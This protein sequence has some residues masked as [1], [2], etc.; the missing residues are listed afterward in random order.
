VN[1]K[2]WKI[3]LLNL[4][5]L[6]LAGAA[7]ATGIDS[8]RLER[9]QSSLYSGERMIVIQAPQMDSAAAVVRMDDKHYQ[10]SLDG[11][12]FSHKLPIRNELHLRIGSFDPTQK[13][14]RNTELL[15][16]IDTDVDSDQK[17]YIVQ[18]ETQ[19]LAPIQEKI[20]HLGGAIYRPLPD[21]ALLVKMDTTTHNAVANLPFV[22]WTGEY[23]VDYKLEPELQSQLLQGPGRTDSTTTRYRVLLL[24]GNYRSEAETEVR[25]LGGEV[26]GGSSQRLLEIRL[27]TRELLS[28][29]Q[30]PYIE[31]VEAWTPVETDMDLVREYGGANFLETIPLPGYS[32]QGVRGEVLDDGLFLHHSDFLA[33]PPLLHGSNQSH[34]SHGTPV[35]GI[36]FGDGSNNA[37]ARGLLPNAEQGIFAS[38][39][40]LDNRECH[41]ARLVDPAGP[42]RA[43]FQTNSWGH[44]RTTEYTS[45]SAQL[46]DIIFKHDLLITQSQSNS[47]NQYSRPE[48]WAKNVVSVGGFRHYNTLTKGS[49]GWH[50]S[51]STGPAADG[52]IK[53]DLSHFYDWTLTTHHHGGYANFG[54]TSNSTPITAGHFGLLFQLWAD[55]VFHGAPGQERDVFDT[56][57]RAATAKALMINTAYQY[58]FAGES[59]D[60]ARVRQGWGT[61]N[62]KNLYQASAE[63]GWE[64]PLLINETEILKP[65]EAHS[66]TLNI[67]GNEPLRVTMVYRDPAGSPSAGIHRVND[68]NLKVIAPD[69]TYYWG[70]NGLLSGNWSTPGGLPNS[71]DTVE[72][73]FIQNPM[74]GEWTIKVRG[75]E[76]VYDTYPTTAEIDAVYALVATARVDGTPPDEPGFSYTGFLPN[77][78]I[79]NQQVEYTT[80]ASFDGQN[81]TLTFDAGPGF[82]WVWVYTPGHRNM[83]Y[84]GDN[85]WQTTLE[86]YH[87]GSNLQFYF[88]VR[89]NGHEASNYSQPHNWIVQ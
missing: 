33:K 41:T 27:P 50:G 5:M 64:L 37:D 56:R 79:N 66:Y 49:H 18:L 52:R 29:A 26:L 73:V 43:V 1:K 19:A 55:G 13:Q 86:G 32:G 16:L 39:L 85:K 89:K 3:V 88:T 23:R 63:N 44:S 12:T 80:T 17:I 62:V 77:G 36:V 45:I 71:V 7:A 75:D 78:L 31:Y 28:L 76:I 8:D 84:V 6:P 60:M 87:E 57:P 72:N 51:A 61:A 46:D 54:G 11:H 15:S 24:S 34:R 2:Q 14:P 40:K 10:V 30:H 21:H 35:Y 42:Y 67:T 38:F 20:R 9:L 48:A 53:P 47:G 68:L 4:L 74:P 58:P 22:R 81:V 25:A 65:M 70:N 82:E 83:Q 59:A 69:G